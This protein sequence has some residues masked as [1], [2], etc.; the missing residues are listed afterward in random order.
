MGIFNNQKETSYKED[1]DKKNFNKKSA[2]S[3]TIKYKNENMK[4]ENDSIIKLP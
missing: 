4:E 2:L 3:S 1:L